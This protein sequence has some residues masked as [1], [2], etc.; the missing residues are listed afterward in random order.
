MSIWRQ[1]GVAVDLS[2]RYVL[3]NTC[4][5]KVS[6]RAGSVCVC[7]L[8]SRGI[9]STQVKE[10]FGVSIDLNGNYLIA[11]GVRVQLCDQ[12]LG[13]CVTAAGVTS[14]C[15]NTSILL[16]EPSCAIEGG[17]GVAVRVPKVRAAR[18]L[19]MAFMPSDMAQACCSTQ[20]CAQQRT[21][22]CL[23]M[24]SLPF[25]AARSS[26]VHSA[27]RNVTMASLPS[28]TAQTCCS[29]QVCSQQ[30]ACRRLYGR[31]CAL[32]DAGSDD[33]RAA[34]DTVVLVCGFFS[35]PGDL[36]HEGGVGW[37]SRPGV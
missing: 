36:R 14:V 13:W 2:G 28:D 29:R 6:R 24:A 16:Q 21:A 1:Q 30:R 26:C 17:T 23:T 35:S 31:I 20:M 12:K 27:T 7:V 32:D 4:D 8:D 33:S 10:P 9:A 3:E 37:R 15:G 25:V 34:S 18:T 19:T 11:D 22:R 5:H